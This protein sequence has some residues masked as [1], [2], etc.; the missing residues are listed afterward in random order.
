M[1]QHKESTIKAIDDYFKKAILTLN[2][3]KQELLDNVDAK[4]SADIKMLIDQEN[5][6]QTYIQNMREYMVNF[7]NEDLQEHLSFTHFVP[8]MIYRKSVHH[9]LALEF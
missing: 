4:T 3:F 8:L 1:P 6:L 9:F 5:T 7:Q 2:W